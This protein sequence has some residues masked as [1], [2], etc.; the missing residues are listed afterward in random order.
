[1]ESDFR[2]Y[3]RRA[4]AERSAAQRALTPQARDRRVQLARAYDMK[5]AQ[6]EGAIQLPLLA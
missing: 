6:C 2:Y 3:M 1:M 4:A 5:A